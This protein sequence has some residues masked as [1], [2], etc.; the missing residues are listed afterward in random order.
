MEIKFKKLSENAVIPSYAHS[1]DAGMDLTA[2]RFTQELDKSG[3]LVLVYHTDIAVEIPKGYVG[4]I[5]MRSS[6]CNKS[7]ALANAV[8]V[9]DSNYR[10][11]LICK[12]KITT[13]A[14]PTIYQPGEKIAQLV[15]LH[16]PRFTP[17]E[18]EE[19]SETDR[20]EGGFGT[21]GDKANIKIED[22]EK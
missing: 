8:G 2:T 10:G 20:G 7:I 14:V 3:K 17:V 19:L 18:A 11:E 1:D 15:I 4:L 21:T 16:N 6:V 9:I 12:F 5:F 22:K 13:D